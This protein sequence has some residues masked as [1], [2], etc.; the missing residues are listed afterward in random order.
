MVNYEV[1]A[2]IVRQG[3]IFVRRLN[4]RKSIEIFIPFTFY[5]AV[6]KITK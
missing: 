1:E 3:Y 4:N 6:E 2:D 5:E